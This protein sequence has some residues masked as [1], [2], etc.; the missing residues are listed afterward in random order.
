MIDE[1]M[2]GRVEGSLSPYANH[3]SHRLAR[4]GRAGHSAHSD[5]GRPR[6]TQERAVPGQERGGLRRTGRREREATGV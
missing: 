6:V 4:A 5:E 1:R 3:T 2:N